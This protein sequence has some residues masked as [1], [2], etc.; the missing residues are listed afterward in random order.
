MSNTLNTAVRPGASLGDYPQR[1]DEALDGFDTLTQNLHAKLQRFTQKNDTDFATFCTALNKASH[2]LPKRADHSAKVM[3]LNLRRQLRSKGLQATLLIETLALLRLFADRHLGLRPY[4]E[5]LFAA[6]IITQGNLAEMATGEGKS[7][8]AALASA[9]VALADI[10]VHTLTTNEY[11]A[12]RDADE[13]QVFFNALGLSAGAVQEDM[14]TIERRNIY[15]RDIAYCTNKQ[16]AF[17]YLRDR[18]VSGGEENR[19]RNSLVDYAPE[20]GP[21]LRGLCFA[22]VDEAD[23]IFIDEACTPL[24]LSREIQDLEREQLYKQALAIAYKLHINQHYL[25]NEGRRELHLSDAGLEAIESYRDNLQG[26]WRGKRRAR[27][28]V[29][30]ALTALHL[31]KRNQHYIVRDDNVEIIDQHTGRTMPDRSW[32]QG[33]H[34]LI[35]CKEGCA[36]SGQRETLARISYQRFFRRYLTLAGMSGT[37]QETRS[38]LLQVYGLPTIAIPRHRSNC[39]SSATEHIFSDQQQR[40]TALIQRIKT[41]HQSGQPLLIATSSVAVSQQLSILLH[42]NALPHRVLNALQDAEEAAVVATA[43]Q[44]GAITV[45]SNMAGRGTDIKLGEGVTTLGG[46]HVIS[47]DR[48]ESRRVDRQLFGRCGRQGDP[49]STEV[50]LALDSQLLTAYY[51]EKLLQLLHNK[52]LLSL[53]NRQQALAQLL[54][55]LPQ[56]KLQKTHKKQRVSTLAQ[57][58]RLEDWLAFSGSQ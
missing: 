33:L 26:L 22:I 16:V 53:L 23:S 30:Q 18:M 46:L 11:L 20:E 29:Q 51:P 8:T 34:Q 4:D 37:L 40:N 56:R 19:L 47:I 49:G 48:N 2:K 44:L 35:E 43:G 3:L 27:Y 28:L 21:V 45:A 14:D 13:M 36:M 54:S 6:Y 24:L 38:E 17:D 12:Q 50:Y 10:P 32:E 15:A 25:L 52:A 7:L 1:S 55:Y 39:V 5:Q 57:D 9:C 42:E 41:L 31:F 58:Q